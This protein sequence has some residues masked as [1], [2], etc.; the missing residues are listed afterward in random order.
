[1]KIITHIVILA[2]CRSCI[3]CGSV[4]RK[5]DGGEVKSNLPHTTEEETGVGAR[6]GERWAKTGGIVERA[7]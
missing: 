4:G 6:G 5:A 3:S 7:R 1:M 2:S